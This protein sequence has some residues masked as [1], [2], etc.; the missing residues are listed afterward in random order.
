MT[1]Q[2]KVIAGVITDPQ[3]RV[4]LAQRLPG[5]HMAGSWEFPGGKLEDG[6]GA[7][8]GLARE[9][10]EELTITVSAATP[11]IRLRH[12]YPDRVVELDIWRVDD[13]AGRP[14]GAE[15]QA[16]RW[17]HVDDLASVDL[18]EADAPIVDALR[19]PTQY[20]ITPP[21]VTGPE[22]LGRFVRHAVANGVGML[23]LRLPGI[24]GE[25]LR[26]LAAAA[27]SAA[28]HCR[29]LINGDPEVAA[30]L[31]R[32]SGAAG[33]HIPSRFLAA[34]EATTRP[35]D[36][37]IGVSC[38]DAGELALAA[39]CGANFAVLG[40]V[41]TTPSHPA[42]TPLGWERF[43]ELAGVANLPVYALGGVGPG[44]ITRARGAGAQGVAGI[45]AFLASF[46]G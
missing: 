25:Q 40:P 21:D 45:S 36:L 12:A 5:S 46:P 44:D 1:R 34:R 30:E 10:G 6:E 28:G 22:R 20:A 3:G 39:R 32:A 33:I 9:L 27:V 18:L 7:R 26:D 37:L 16:L 17:V 31:A 13:Y 35:A 41:L 43:A 23:Q 24:A 8:D 38:H 4:L 42:A 15:G 2:I 11:L 14:V 29:V 19:L